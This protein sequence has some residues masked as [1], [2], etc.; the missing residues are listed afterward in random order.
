MSDTKMLASNHYSDDLKYNYYCTASTYDNSFI[1]ELNSPIM[2]Y[3]DNWYYIEIT[4][5]KVAINVIDNI[6]SSLS[7]ST[8]QASNIIDCGSNQ[9]GNLNDAY[10]T[11]ILDGAG[12]LYTNGNKIYRIT[13]SSNNSNEIIKEEIYK[14]SN[15]IVGLRIYNGRFQIQTARNYASKEITL[16]N[17]ALA[18]DTEDSNDRDFN[19]E[20]LNVNSTYKLKIASKNSDDECIWSSSDTNVATIDNNGVLKTVGVGIANITLTQGKQ[21]RTMLIYVRDYVNIT[22]KY[23]SSRATVYL[24]GVEI[25]AGNYSY[26]KGSTLNVNIICDENYFNF[27][28]WIID[29][30]KIDYRTFEINNISK[31]LELVAKVDRCYSIDEI[32]DL[33]F[34]YKYYADNNADLKKAFGYNETELRNHYIKYGIK[35]GRVASNLFD[36]KY[37]LNNNAD[38]KKT[39]GDDYTSAYN[40][41]VIYGFREGRPS[42]KIYYGLYYGSAYKDLILFDS[43]DLMSHFKNYG[44][45]EG[46]KATN[47]IDLTPIDITGYL[48][49]STF[50][51]DL[52]EDVRKFFGYNE[53][54]LRNHYINYGIKEGRIAS[55]FFDPK[56]YL[57][58]YSDLKDAFGNN[59]T[60]AYNHFIKNGINEGRTA[61]IYFDVNYYLNNYSDL[62][63]A[64]GSNYSMALRHFYTN[65]IK[66]GRDASSLFKILVYKS[67]YN[68]LRIAYGDNNMKYFIHYEKYGKKEGRK[69]Y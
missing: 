51:A 29:G 56:Y 16:T 23:K 41:F 7:K 2:E 45:K 38:L 55:I 44:L 19:K 39:F 40:H 26:P 5:N 46:R 20:I 57:N 60:L 54:E 35:E 43:Y 1:H 8:V 3:E 68:D 61:S 47:V 53:T 69:A 33:I 9:F 48:F 25:E 64:F 58:K 17:K 66:E 63:S 12:I 14:D 50:Y 10:P 21:V 42:S 31:D 65:G 28:G 37:Y 27:K 4:N 32:E 18:I 15:K 36:V 67:S 49:N 62:K 6:D 13:Y 11:I 30:E 59:Y 52:Y 22:L 24:N 34:D